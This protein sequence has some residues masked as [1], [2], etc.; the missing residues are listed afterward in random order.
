MPAFERSYAAPALED[1]KKDTIGRKTYRI[2]EVAKTLKLESYVLRFWESEFP[3]LVPLR[4]G[5]GQRLYTEEHV[6]LLRQIQTLLHEKGMTIEGARRIL[7]Q[8]ESNRLGLANL[9]PVAAMPGAATQRE[10]LQQ[11]VEEL[12]VLKRLLLPPS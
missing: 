3:Q 4:T 6:N 2:G 7:E 8:E 1:M 12:E 10:L 11:C 5:K 9:V